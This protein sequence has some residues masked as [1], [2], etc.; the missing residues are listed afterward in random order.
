MAM[1]SVGGPHGSGGRDPLLGNKIAGA[2]LGS[3]L[4]AMGL[5]IFSGIIYTPKKPA[6]PGYDL[7][8]PEVGAPAG[9]GDQQAQAEP[10]PVR[11]AS[12]DPAKGQASSKKCLACHVLEK[13]GPNKIGPGL[14]G[15]IGHPKAGHAGFNYSAAMKAKGGEWTFD[16]LDH[17]LANP[18]G[19]VPGTIMAFAGISNPKERA[20]LIRYLQ[21]LSDSPVPLPAAE[22]APA[23]QPAA[24]PGASQTQQQPTPPVPGQRA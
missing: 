15:V 12:A 2:V 5:N 19:Y 3:L 10:L 21:T 9:G 6:V 8:A 4:F 11:L 18:K 1:H 23:V 17:F 7:P 22:A 13:G 14:Y 24:A 20:D 16:D